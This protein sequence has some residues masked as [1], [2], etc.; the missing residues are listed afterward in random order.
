MTEKEIFKELFE[1]ARK[2]DDTHG[3]VAAALVRDGEILAKE[4]SAKD[5]VVHAEHALL[6]NLKEKDLIVQPNDIVYVT[7]EPCSHRSSERERQEMGDDTT[8][9]LD[10]GV[11]HVIFAAQDPTADSATRSRF[12]EA[13]VSIEQVDDEAIIKE[14]IE[15]F[16]ATCADTS[17]HLPEQK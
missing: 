9:L 16:N 12:K 14:A 11:R 13:G 4:A 6:E 10:A 1:L 17:K 2:A 15:V 7:L 8:H 5:G 3:A